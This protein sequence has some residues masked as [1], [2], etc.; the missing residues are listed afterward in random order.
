MNSG[1]TDSLRITKITFTLT[2]TSLSNHPTQ[3]LFIYRNQLKETEIYG[4]ISILITAK[5]SAAKQQ[6]QPA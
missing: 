2:M 6:D 5:L 4:M 3:L 1:R